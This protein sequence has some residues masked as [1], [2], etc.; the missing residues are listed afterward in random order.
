[1]TKWRTNHGDTVEV[2]AT[3][4]ACLRPE[5]TTAH[6]EYR[7]RIRAANGEIVEHGEAYSRKADAIEAAGRHH[8]RVES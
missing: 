4:A 2:Y 6:R 5:C 7:Y 1:M 3:A 8:P